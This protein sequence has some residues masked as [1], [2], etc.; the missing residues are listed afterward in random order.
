MTN[1]DGTE[2]KSYK[3]PQG[4]RIQAVQAARELKLAR[5]PMVDSVYQGFYIRFEPDSAQGKRALAGSEGI[6]GSRLSAVLCENE[7]GCCG[8][9]IELKA[10]SGTSLVVL[11][12]QEAERIITAIQAGWNVNTYLSLVVFS[13]EKDSFWAEA[14]CIL[15]N[16]EQEGPLKN[17]TKNIVYR[18]NRGTHPGLELN[19]EQFIHII[20]S[21]G[22]WYLT[23]DMPLPALKQGEII[24]RRRKVWSE[25]LVEAAA[26]GKV[27]CKA[28]AILF[29][30]IILVV[31]I[32]LVGRLVF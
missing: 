24:Y 3:D 21:N 31:V 32:W 18:I 19:Q 27:G 11:V 9:G 8:H 4:D 5:F 17:F 25:Y 14:A 7:P 15:F 12:G 10:L 22:N 16:S 2:S 1:R 23:K 30:L 6:V 20:E 28:A 26:S 29:W 13:K